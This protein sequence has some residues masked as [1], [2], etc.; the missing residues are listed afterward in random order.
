MR[1]IGIHPLGRHYVLQNMAGHAGFVIYNERENVL[2][3]LWII[4]NAE[5][6]YHVAM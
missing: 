1:V 3:G 2:V 6:R 4:R 5:L